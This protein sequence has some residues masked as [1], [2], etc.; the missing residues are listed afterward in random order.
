MTRV[1]GA[2]VVLFAALAQVTWAQDLAVQGVF[3]NFVLA[4]VVAIAWTYGPRAGLAWACVGGLLLD[5]AAPG[6]LGPHALAL[7]CGA[8]IAGAW[9]R[10]VERAGVVFPALAAAMA[11]AI[12]AIVLLGV[13]DTLNLAMPPL[14]IAARL[15]ALAALYNAVV[16][17]PVIIAIGR[18][19]SQVHA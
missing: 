7:L 14:G 9:A 2:L 12:Y 17:V 5:L 6:P 4:V 13:D 1:L 19:H 10:N 18:S 3:P 16:T 15:T 11:T 8:Y